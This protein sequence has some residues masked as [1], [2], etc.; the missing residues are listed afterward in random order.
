MRV[1]ID[2]LRMEPD[3]ASARLLAAQGAAELEWHGEAVALLEPVVDRISIGLSYDLVG[4]VHPLFVRSLLCWLNEHFEARRPGLVGGRVLSTGEMAVSP[5]DRIRSAL[6]VLEANLRREADPSGLDDLAKLK[7][8]YAIVFANA[9]MSGRAPVEDLE[10]AR[11]VL[12]V[13]GIEV[14]EDAG[15]SIQVRYQKAH[16]TNALHGQLA[17]LEEGPEG[18]ELTPLALPY[19][20]GDDWRGKP[21]T[22]VF[23]SLGD[24]V[25]MVVTTLVPRMSR[26]QI[27]QV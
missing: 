20:W 19:F 8:M 10:R 17:R 4:S 22:V 6:A 12:G 25:H 13:H 2:R 9:V 1:S 27:L 11:T 15:L 18:W 3:H 5:F 7:R 14:T 24:L 16:W 26:A 23:E 21:G